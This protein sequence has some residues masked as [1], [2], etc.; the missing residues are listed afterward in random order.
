[1]TNR[2]GDVFLF[3][4]LLSF[5]FMGDI[6]ESLRLLPLFLIICAFTKRAQAPFSRW[7]PMAIRAPTPVSSLVHSRTLVT[8]GLYL[9]IK[10]SYF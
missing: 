9:L 3:I 1:M 4:F 7:L 8:A 5:T 10:Y 6:S 2:L